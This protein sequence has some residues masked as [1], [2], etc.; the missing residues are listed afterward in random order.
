MNLQASILLLLV[1][2]DR[3]GERDAVRNDYNGRGCGR[4]FLC[5][6]LPT[7]EPFGSALIDRILS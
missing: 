6:I 3:E 5:R 4:L 2:S 7:L 1:S